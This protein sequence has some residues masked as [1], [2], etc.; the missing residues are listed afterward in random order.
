MWHMSESLTIEYKLLFYLSGLIRP[1]RRSGVSPCCGIHT[2]QSRPRM[3]NLLPTRGDGVSSGCGVCCACCRVGDPPMRYVVLLDGVD[4]L[5]S[6]ARSATP[7]CGPLPGRRRSGRLCRNLYAWPS[8]ASISLSSVQVASTVAE[9][10]GLTD[11]AIGSRIWISSPARVDVNLA[12]PFLPFLPPAR[13]RHGGRASPMGGGGAAGGRRSRTQTPARERGEAKVGGT[14]GVVAT[15]GGGA[16][17][18]GGG[19]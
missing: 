11:G 3:W 17:A 8:R 5:S 4:Q 19:R 6:S 10:H 16:A 1:R 9:G 14:S 2:T 12:R 15:A 7:R 13:Q 18:G